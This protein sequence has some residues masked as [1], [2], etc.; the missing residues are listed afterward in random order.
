MTD[1]TKR[2]IKD[3]L[4]DETNG[5]MMKGT[6]FLMG[7]DFENPK[8]GETTE[9]RTDERTIYMGLGMRVYWND[10][11]LDGLAISDWWLP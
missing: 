4:K 6:S 9:G 7:G 3:W 5:A 10:N 1:K 2:W 11:G 8:I